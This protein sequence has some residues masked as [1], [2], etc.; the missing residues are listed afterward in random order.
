[1]RNLTSCIC[2]LGLS[3]IAYGDVLSDQIGDMDGSG[4]GTN[5]MASQDFEDAYEQYSV[6]VASDF[7]GDGGNISM[8]ECVVGGWNGFVDPSSIAGYSANLYSTAD[9]ACA[10]LTGDIASEYVDAADATISADWMGANFLIMMDT[11]LASNN[12]PQMFGVVPA[13][14]FAT[15][16]QTG[17]A[18]SVIGGGSPDIQ[19]NPGGGFGF[20]VQEASEAAYRLTGGAPADPCSLPLPATC[21]A[22]VDGDGAVAVSDVLE[23]IATW[24]SSGD[25]SFRPSGDCAPMPNGDCTVDVADILEVIGQWGS[26][27]AVYGG[28][29]YGDGS[30]ATST[31][32]DC[33]AAGGSYFGDNTDCSSGSCVAG[34]CCLSDT[35]CSDMTS[36]ACAGMGGSYKGD[37]TD[38][39]T[40][41]CAAVE[42]GD[43]ADNAIV[44]Y[45]GGTAFNSSNCT[46]S[47]EGHECAEDAGAFGWTDPTPDIWLAFTATNSAGYA[48]DTCDAGSFDTSII[49]Y[50]G[51]S[52]NQIAC[53]GDGADLSGCQTYYSQV[54][55][56]MVA[57]NTYMVRI[58]GFAAT[59]FGPG[60]LNINEI[61]PP[62]DGACCFPDESCL[63]NLNST[64]C[65]A[66]GGVFAGEGTAC[67]DDVCL[68]GAGD[69][70]DTAVVATVG[71]NS[72]DTTLMTPSEPEPD[73]SQ[74]SG[75]YLDWGGSQDAWMVWTPD[76]DGV[77]SFSACDSSS[78]DTSMVLYEGTCDNQVAC[79]GDATGES[80]CQ[81]YYS[82]IYDFPVSGGT[83][84]YI[85]MGGW[86][87]AVGAGTVTISFA[88]GDQDGACCL[89]DG[90]CVD[91]TSSACSG[92][93]GDWSSSGMCADVTCPQPWDGCPAGADSNCDPC[94]YDGDDSAADCNGGN[95]APTPVFQDITLGT[96]MCGTHSV[97]VDGPTGGTYRDLDWY[98]NDTVNAGGNFTVTYGTSG[99]G[100][101]GLIYDAVA[102][103]ALVEVNVAEGGG[104]NSAS[105]DVPAGDYVILTAPSE[106]NTAWTC[107]SGLVDYWILVE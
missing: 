13:N 30:C 54:D 52:S 34:A 3:G 102:G 84:Y 87:A 36:D 32:S 70:C 62:A 35:D 38:C 6:V 39:A 33:A 75:T 77:A 51:S 50:E 82:A 57:G 61:P 49:I 96:P 17:I 48:I 68:A 53:N 80:G 22:D 72:F 10:S 9:S 91:A 46:P 18:D 29:C 43:E 94:W 40:T 65:A 5:I 7:L 45:E 71:A 95:N 1:M 37:G 83:P 92:L 55:V 12:G 104:V 81:S 23:V 8:V 103:V 100:G 85:R 42:P 107:D 28:C 25:G 31:A 88:G 26:D 73:D 66:F 74:C 21:N 15:G 89:P 69:E 78:Y 14:D 99:C 60:T 20:C 16:G 67:A 59:D 4:I 79:N 98:V 47:S 19:A 101:F 58:G 76:S 44:V 56:D 2:I 63:D 24:G 41:D 97:F 106:W 86:N 93:G 64:D 105:G 90:S 11:A 27:C